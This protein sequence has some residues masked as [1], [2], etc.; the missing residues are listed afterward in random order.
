VELI[1][2]IKSGK[3]KV[4]PINDRDSNTQNC[5]SIVSFIMLL[6]SMSERKFSAEFGFVL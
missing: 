2:F 1:S 6:A 5:D 4:F 3:N